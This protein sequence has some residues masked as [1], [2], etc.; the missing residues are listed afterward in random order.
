MLWRAFEWL[1]LSVSGSI[2]VAAGQFQC[3]G[4]LLSGCLGAESSTLGREKRQQTCFNALA[5]F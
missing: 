4:E 3:S 2:D 5:S 1:S